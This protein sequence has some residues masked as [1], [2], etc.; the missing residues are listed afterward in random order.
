MTR[1]WMVRWRDPSTEHGWSDSPRSATAECE[2]L[3]WITTEDD[4]GI[5]VA[6]T[7]GPDGLLCPIHIPNE[8][9]VE[10]VRL[11]MDR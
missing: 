6:P 5:I 7:R 11:R 10:R 8:C 9:I 3:G 2:T 4:G 1:M